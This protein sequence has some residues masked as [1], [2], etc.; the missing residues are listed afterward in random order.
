[1][2]AL[3]VDQS[4]VMAEVTTDWSKIGTQVSYQDIKLKSKSGKDS[5]LISYTSPLALKLAAKASFDAAQIADCLT[6]RLNDLQGDCDSLSPSED[7]SPLLWSQFIVQQ[8]ELGWIYLDLA[9]V[10]IAIWLEQLAIVQPHQNKSYQQVKSA[11]VIRQLPFTLAVP[12]KRPPEMWKPVWPQA[13]SMIWAA[14]Y[15]H[16][17]TSSLLQLAI[18]EGLLSSWANTEIVCFGRANEQISPFYRY[19]WLDEQEQLRLRHPSEW[20][21]IRCFITLTDEW[22]DRER[23]HTPQQVSRQ[24]DLLIRCFEQFYRQCLIFGDVAQQ[25]PELAQARLG[26]VRITQGLMGILL[27]EGL[28]V[29]ALTE[30]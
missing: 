25:Q 21:L 2:S 24:I 13:W 9:D 28:G 29:E 1:M 5:T 7:F 11:P 10:G 20:D 30:L 18:R 3:V 15:V 4:Q 16:A 17:R 12:Q 8:N 22:A 23:S 19:P 26:L 6:C 14:Q 27:E